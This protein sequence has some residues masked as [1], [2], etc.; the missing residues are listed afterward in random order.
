ML[1]SF[2]IKHVLN[3]LIVNKQMFDQISKW[4]ELLEHRMDSDRVWVLTLGEIPYF[5]AVCL[6]E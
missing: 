2:G 1:N 3:E 4:V 5:A 6:S